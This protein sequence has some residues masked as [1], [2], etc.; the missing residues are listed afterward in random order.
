METY[1]H[2]I[3]ELLI[4][5]VA[6]VLFFFQGYDKVFCMKNDEIYKAVCDNFNRVKLPPIV[7]KAG[8]SLTSF[9][10]LMAGSML[11]LGL[12]KYVA[13]YFLSF[14][15]LVIAFGFSISKPMWDMQYYLP[16]L[17]LVVALL[18]M[19]FEWGIFSFD[20]FIHH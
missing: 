4:R 9:I 7:L 15:L 3:A 20:Y 1:A 13:L 6:G 2:H 11:V 10:E 17:I 12:F 16:R 19:P 18:I 5:V 8:I 14:D